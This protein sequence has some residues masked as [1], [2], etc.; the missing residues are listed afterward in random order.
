LGDDGVSILAQT[1]SS[2]NTSLQKL[3]LVMNAIT[4]TGV[5]ALLGMM[6]QSCQIT[7]LE[8]RHNHI[9]NEGA[10]L[11]AKALESNSLPNLK[12]LSLSYC[13][14][15]DDGFI[16]L[17]SALKQNTSLL[18]LDLRYNYG[19]SERAF[20]ALAESIPDIKALQRFDLRWCEGLVSTMPLL[21]VGLHKNT[22]LFRFYVE[23][24]SALLV[25][26]L[27]LEET[28]RYAGGWTQ[29]LER[30][31]RRNCFLPLLRAPKERLPPRGVWPRALA[32]VATLPDVIFEVFRSKPSLV[33]SEDA[34][35]K[36]A[37]QD[38]G[39]A[40]KRKRGDE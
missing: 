36:E 12:H 26:P 6:E 13:S 33:P 38:I 34:E 23:K 25:P 4:F 37:A 22:S 18:H 17:I 40:R 8:L 5:G 31:G 20:S 21:L 30:L 10:S 29:E 39:V 35:G 2:R 9:G 15:D 3:T 7:E 32:R 27:K 28:S 19:L 11:L 14:I 1:L 24:G 16:T